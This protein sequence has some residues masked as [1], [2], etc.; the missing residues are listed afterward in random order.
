MRRARG[1]LAVVASFGALAGF[2]GFGCAPA[3][4]S[5]SRGVAGRTEEEVAARRVPAA[6]AAAESA[7]RDGG[8]GD[9]KAVHGT[10]DP[11]T[12]ERTEQPAIEA[13]VV[14]PVRGEIQAGRLRQAGEEY[15]PAAG[16][17]PYGWRIQVYAD[18]SFVKASAQAGR[19]KELVEGSL[20]VYVEFIDPYYKVRVGDFADQEAARPALDRMRALGFSD[21][22]SV[23]TTIKAGP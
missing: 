21:A 8:L 15:A 6:E 22:W 10:I 18:A 3:T 23:R 19:T 11:V 14:E 5:G 9:A 1:G 7:Q 20:P 13:R 12:G 17:I 4:T 16:E 2:L